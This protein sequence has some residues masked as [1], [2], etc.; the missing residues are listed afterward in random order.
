MRAHILLELIRREG[1]A[2][3]QAVVQLIED[4]LKLEC[5]PKARAEIQ[6]AVALCT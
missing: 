3:G 5:T 6:S 1:F 4:Q 2:A